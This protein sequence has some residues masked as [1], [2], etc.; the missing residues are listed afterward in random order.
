MLSLATAPGTAACGPDGARAAYSPSADSTKSGPIAGQII[1]DPENAAWLAYEDGMS[2]YMCGPGDPEGFLYRGSRS[3]DGTRDGDQLALIEKL[4]PTGANSIYLMAVRSHGG[5]GGR[6]ENPFIDS[7]ED[8]GV[9]SEILNQWATWFDAMESWGIAIFFIMYD[10]GARIWDTGD[11]VGPQE[12]A[13]IQTIV[14]RFEGYPNLIWVVA[15]EYSEAF[16]PARAANIAAEI[17]ATDDHDHVIAVHQLSGLRFDFPD[18]PTV[19]QFAI[20]YDTRSDSALH[21]AA[22]RAF[23]DAGGR[24]N[25]NMA[26]VSRTD[27]RHHGS[28]AEARRKNWAA[29]MGGANVMALGWDIGST[30]TQDL[31]Q[32]GYLVRFM[33]AGNLSEMAPRDDL[34]FGDTRY[35]LAG[36]GNEH[37]LY[38][39]DATG[40]VGLRQL[41]S[42]TYDLVWL[43]PITGATLEQLNRSTAGG[44]HAWEIPIGFGPEV[45]V[46]IHPSA[47]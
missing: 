44:N 40:G 16:S 37:I 13:Y 5:D 9:S 20:Q 46:R 32:C 17:R 25:L 11:A 15:E 41:A 14:N 36:Q 24:F 45:A 2:F 38:A 12:R 43:D 29:A 31:Q 39:T 1:V 8:K 34:V 7:D 35:V 23:A 30:P 22:V 21:A 18:D 6:T 28:G 27:R 47:R 19:D 42:G 4:G 33:E 26:E 10:D 3:S